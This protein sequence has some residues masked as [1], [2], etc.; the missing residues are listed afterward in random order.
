MDQNGGRSEATQLMIGAIEQYRANSGNPW[1][2]PP[3][4]EAELSAAR[5]ALAERFVVHCKRSEYDVYIGR[6]KCPR[7][8]HYYGWGNRFEIG[9][10]GT[11]AEVIAKYRTWIYTQPKLLE[12]AR[13]TL[14]GKVLGCWC[15]PLDCH[16]GVLAEIANG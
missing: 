14:K 16:G 9:R 13:R 3:Y 4:T 6:G 8:G 11:R 7:T 10:D 5:R 15:A 2:G 12:A 1:G